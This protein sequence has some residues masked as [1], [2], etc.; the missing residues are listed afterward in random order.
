LR[1]GQIEIGDGAPLVLVSGLNVLETLQGAVDCARQLV[2]LGERHGLPV[3]FKASFDKANRTRI[4]GYRGPGLDAGLEML[5][6]VK[7]ETG[8]PILTDV[9]EPAQAAVVA[10]VADCLQVPAF[11]CR[12]TDLLRACAETG[13]A[14]NVK[15]GQFVASDEMAHAVDKLRCFGSE[16]VL[17]TERGN[18]FGHHDLI[19]DFRG[20][21]AMRAVAPVC[22]DATHATQQ[23]GARNGA[24][25][26]L[27]AAV[28]PLSR[29]AVAVGIDALFI[30]IHPDPA[31][32]P[33]DGDCQLTPKALSDLLV[34]VV[35]IDDALRQA[36]TPG[37]VDR[38]NTAPR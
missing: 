36:R 35:A 26:G 2:G 13:R 8:L 19:V 16:D 32:A 21:A 7:A 5:A 22:F 17:V 1:I 15:K 23:P 25:G 28:A 38:S 9:H 31:Q 37:A 18:S 10:E 12:Q 6:R 3:V 30:E 27:R 34:D 24:S 33:V 11:L 14:V 29:A 4:D 20:L